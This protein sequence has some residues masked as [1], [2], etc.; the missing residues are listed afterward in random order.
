MKRLLTF[1]LLLILLTACGKSEPAYTD[2]GKPG[3]IKAVVFYDNN[4]NGTM[5]SGETGAPVEVAISQDISCP[6]A[7][8]DKNTIVSADANGIALFKDLKP[9]KYCVGANGNYS[10][11]TKATQDVYV[12]SDLVATVMFG[13]V[14]DQ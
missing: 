14:K 10:M 13:I 7:S 1:G 11:T 12:S 6:P 5:D 9:G 8:K 2:N 3:Q 4:K